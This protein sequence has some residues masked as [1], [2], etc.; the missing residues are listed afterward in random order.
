MLKGRIP[1]FQ[2][3]RLFFRSKFL[4]VSASRWLPETLAD[5]L[6]PSRTLVVD[7]N[8]IRHCGR[9]WLLKV[10]RHGQQQDWVHSSFC[11]PPALQ[12]SIFSIRKQ[13]MSLMSHGRTRHRKSSLKL[14][15][16]L[17]LAP[18]GSQDLST[19][20]VSAFFQCKSLLPCLLK[21]CLHLWC[22]FISGV[23]SSLWCVFISVVCLHLWLFFLL[24]IHSLLSSFFLS[25]A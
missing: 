11:I 2:S 25:P 14:K 23:S 8:H 1:V 13:E 24:S 6:L 12:S 10:C 22:V 21:V 4:I 5:T 19:T 20:I 9:P 7:I 15:P 17:I 3:H 18:A 16:R